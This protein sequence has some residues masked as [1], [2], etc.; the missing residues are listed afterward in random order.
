MS[1]SNQPQVYVVEASA[2]SGKT[3][4]LAKRYISLLL[5]SSPQQE[6][7]TILKCILAITFTNKATIEMKERIIEFLKIIAFDLFPNKE[8]EKD[9]FQ[10]IRLEKKLPRKGLAN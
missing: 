2:G 7:E 9:I 10:S 5:N 8:F 3:Y 4:A 6:K 1:P